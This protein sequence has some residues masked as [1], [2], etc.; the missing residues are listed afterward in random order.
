[1][2]FNYSPQEQAFAEEVEQW[3]V[4][5]HDPVVMDLTRENFTQLADTAARS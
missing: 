2:D 1:M 3:L 5:N 4:D